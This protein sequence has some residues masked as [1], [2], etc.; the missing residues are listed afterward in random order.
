[1]PLEFSPLTGS[2][3]L[4]AFRILPRT[5]CGPNQTARVRES[6][7]RSDPSRSHDRCLLT[8]Y[9][10]MLS[11]TPDRYHRFKHRG[12]TQLASEFATSKYSDRYGA[13][14]LQG[15]SVDSPTLRRVAH[16]TVLQRSVLARVYSRTKCRSSSRVLDRTHPAGYERRSVQP[17]RLRL[18]F[19]ARSDCSYGLGRQRR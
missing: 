14:A 1:V 15:D 5:K 9:V 16:F 8:I 6:L 11:P 3:C 17:A 18:C 4:W 13:S 12:S 7:R 2:R 19:R 10:P